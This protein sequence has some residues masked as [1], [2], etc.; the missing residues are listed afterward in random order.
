MKKRVASA[1]TN[2]NHLL[3]AFSSTDQHTSGCRTVLGILFCHTEYE[4]DVNARVNI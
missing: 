3:S 1:V 2:S 4:K